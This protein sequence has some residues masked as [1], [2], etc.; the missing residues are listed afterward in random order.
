MP[1]FKVRAPDGQEFNVNGPEGSTIEDAYAY[2][3]ANLWTP[4]GAAP[5]PKTGF[6]PSVI[7]G[8]KQL[9]SLV[10]DVLPAMA[11]K[12][13]GKDEYAAKQ[14]EE[15]AATQKE[16]QEKY[17]ARVPSYKDIKSVGDAIDYAVESVGELVPSMIPGLI[18][19]GVGGVA[20]RGL[21]VGAQTAAK[22]AAKKELMKDSVQAAIKSGAYGGQK[23]TLAAINTLAKEAAEK[24]AIKYVQRGQI[25]GAALS[26]GAQNI[27]EVYSNVYEAVDGQVGGKELAT[28]LAAGTFNTALDTILPA[29]LLKKITGVGLSPN[30]VALAWYKRLGKGGA[31]GFAQ[32]GATET[33]QEMSSAAAE[34]FVNENKNFFTEDNFERFLN[35]GLKGGIGGG[36]ATGVTDVLTGKGPAKKE[37]QVV[38]EI[39]KDS[40][41]TEE[42]IAEV[43]AEVGKS[44]TFEELQEKVKN[45]NKKIDE[46]KNLDDEQ[47]AVVKEELNNVVK[48]PAVELTD[49]AKQLIAVAETKGIPSGYSD[50]QLKAIAKQNGAT[51]NPAVDT[52]EDL[53]AQLKAKLGEQDVERRDAEAGGAGADVS[54][55]RRAEDT[56][57]AEALDRPGMDGDES[58]VVT[59][60]DTAGDEQ[61]T[62]EEQAALQ[63]EL[64]QELGG[65]EV[66][67]PPVEEAV[68]EEEEPVAEKKVP[69]GRFSE[70]GKLAIQTAQN[71][72]R[73]QAAIAA[74]INADNTLTKE[75]K[76]SA[77]AFNNYMVV[78]DNNIKRAL[79][80]L[81]ADLY[82]DAANNPYMPNTGGV[83]AKRFYDGLNPSNKKIVDERLTFLKKQGKGRDASAEKAEAREAEARKAEQA[84]E[85]DETALLR[86][87]QIYGHS[88]KALI[89]SVFLGDTRAA[90][91]EIAQGKGFRQLDRMIAKRIL[92]SKTFPEIEIVPAETLVDEQGRQA[93]GQYVTQSDTAQ[94]AD[95]QVDSHSVLHEVSHGYLHALIRGFQAGEISNK[96]LT[97]LNNLFEYLKNNHPELKG[98]YGMG[99][100]S[101]FASEVMSNPDFQLQLS[102]IPYQR[103]NAFTAFAQAVLRMMG[104]SPNDRA[105][106][107]AAAL[108]AVDKSL[109]TGRLFQDNEVTGKI[110]M[111]PPK[112][113]KPGEAADVEGLAGVAA[114]TKKLPREKQTYAQ[115]KEGLRKDVENKEGAPQVKKLFT[116]RE[117]WNW[118]VRKFQNSRDVLKRIQKAMG[119]NN[120]LISQG[121]LRNDVAAQFDL[122]SALSEINYNE[123]LMPLYKDI[124]AMAADY[125][126][127]SGQS[128]EEAMAELHLYAELKHEP[129]RRHIL[130][131]LNVPLKDEA[132][133]IRREILSGVSK[134]QG[135]EAQREAQA[136]QYR[137]LL[138]DI[139]ADKQNLKDPLSNE[140]QD[141]YNV[142]AD[143]SAQEVQEIR[144]AQM[145]NPQV[146]K[147]VEL[148]D[149]I[150]DRVQQVN[151]ATAEL[152]KIGHYWSTPVDN[153]VMFYG[154]ENYV[155]FKGRPDQATVNDFADPFSKRLAGDLSEGQDA[156]QGR[157]TEAENIILRTMAEGV[158]SAVRAGRKDLTLAIKNAV[159]GGYLKG[160][161]NDFGKGE[162]GKPVSFE[163]RY[164]LGKSIKEISNAT[165]IFHYNDD[166]TIDIISLT[167]PEQREA[168]RRTFDES[169]QFV[170]MLNSFTSGMGQMHTRYN[171]SFGPI[172][173]AGDVLTN[174]FTMGV[175]LGPKATFDLIKT[176]AAQVGRGGLFK[177][178]KA[179]YL[180]NQGK[181]KELAKYTDPKSPNY[182]PFYENLVE[183]LERGGKVSYVQGF[184]TKSQTDL[185]R[186]EMRR[187]GKLVTKADIDKVVDVWT[188]AFELASRAA[189]YKVAKEKYL[190][191][192]AS[193]K[194]M[195]PA[196]AAE[197]AKSRA[198]YYAKNLANFEQVGE[199]GKTFGALFMFARPAATG[200]V[201]AIEALQPLMSKIA[202]KLGAGIPLTAEEEQQAKN[203]QKMLIGL[204]GMGYAAWVMSYMMAD[205][206]DQDRNRTAV[207][208]M[209]RWVR[210][211]RFPLPKWVTGEDKEIILQT[212]W[213]FGLG[214]FASA[215]AQV[216]G[217]VH[218]SSSLGKGL[219]NIMEA[220][221]DSFLPLPI[222]RISVLENPA[223]WFMDSATPSAFRPFM[224]YVMNVD[225][226]GRE[227]Y[228]NRQSRA[229][230][231]YT[232]GDNI[233]EGYKSAA[234][235]LFDV[236]QGG[237]DVSPNTLYFFASN[238]VDGV[239]RLGNGAY[240]LGLTATGEKAFNPKTDTILFDSFF[241]SPS[242]IDSREFS[243]MEKEIKAL[244]IRIKTLQKDPENLA[245]FLESNPDAM[246][247]VAYYN[248]AVNGNLKTLRTMANNVRASRDLSPKE[249]SE[250]LKDIVRMQNL[251][252]RSIL[253]NF[254]A[255][256]ED[257][258]D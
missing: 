60:Q 240:N 32:E 21:T 184:A 187:S 13:V 143:R 91:Q 257:L 248:Q 99:D 149:S 227:I 10:G 206:D 252:K 71:Y 156:M 5:E 175:D 45:I 122:S 129:E 68:A 112:V 44:A 123:Y 39:T 182:D 31:K 190:Q 201:R 85:D 179:A 235:M 242:N 162:K 37:K 8:G 114:G 237:I 189:A 171:P 51:F 120:V 6:I 118:W 3:E 14:M 132:A 186:A 254:E 165:N 98:Q 63:A 196:E 100:L 228:N 33:V 87:T 202:N 212:R 164:I 30:E 198:T 4:K 239:A 62:L 141:R 133:T 232:G 24:A 234:R 138:E 105:T 158:K 155:P 145:A 176:V 255:L 92:E 79:D 78:S 74:E 43:K 18:T 223:A 245:K 209:D 80:L 64:D 125:A 218:G 42:E 231:A 203:A 121:E 205:D 152:N 194:G 109:A 47:K 76:E 199:Y 11:A 139:V 148:L 61:L 244:D 247:R 246:Y 226:L 81:A 166:G 28:A 207:D 177:A 119:R 117:G 153:I 229:G 172:N 93:S 89:R 40:E 25:A 167:D 160:R 256:D 108:I 215:G 135:P 52:V 36:T 193:K 72:R 110:A 211:M 67:E 77:T 188:D 38:K 35:A 144:A 46:S 251:V 134:L 106:A 140:N 233:P 126:K 54:G 131:L 224:E 243:D 197:D 146:S 2:V 169:H 49:E 130:Y 238:Y 154:Y 29:S 96:G 15:Y 214:A 58:V 57:G 181:M 16:I 83:N 241:G 26:S 107:L 113:I 59:D 128:F 75:E 168:I 150:M 56:A 127:A 195:S 230:N 9:S 213:G 22:E 34:K 97:D 50:K 161:I 204:A 220:G 23:E 124:N 191:E 137:Q 173:F 95:G 12:A 53:I 69:G 200:A 142:I 216:A 1:K 73:Q 178:G 111:P 192:N 236:T 102:K 157:A 55:E 66:I 70:T 258:E 217:M 90:L 222:S 94:I 170:D 210:Y 183:Y 103:V 101:E 20:A 48:P 225:S 163:D 41:V 65:Q 250:T 17:P 208:D 86:R 185:A 88:T 174:A 147:H 82:A 19:G 115:A 104:I 253:N 219:E 151:K 221:L 84:V 249:R 7:R 136:K 27:P 159:A 116:S 180:Y